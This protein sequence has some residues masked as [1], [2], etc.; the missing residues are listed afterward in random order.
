MADR[1][2]SNPTKAAREQ[3]QAQKMHAKDLIYFRA[4]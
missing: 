1:A 2:S 3:T 4:C